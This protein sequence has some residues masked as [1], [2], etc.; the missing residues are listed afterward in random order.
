MVEW[1]I[2]TM[3]EPRELL[4]ANLPLIERAISFACGRFRLGPDDADEFA[5]IVKLRL[6]EKDFA[7]LRAWEGRSSLT[8]YIGTVV[9]RLALDYRTHAWGKWRASAEA[10]RLGALAVDLEQLLYRD[11]R[12]IEDVVAVLAA[13]Y[14]GITRES[15][16]ALAARL[17]ERAP[18]RRD[19][20]LDAAAS[21]ATPQ[22]ASPEEH[23]LDQE[24]RAASQHVSGV[25]A[26]A[27]QKL[28]EQDRLIMQLRFEEGMTVPQIAR[29]LQLDQRQLYHRLERCTLELRRELERE[30]IAARDVADLIGRSETLIRFD[31]VKRNPRP[32]KHH[33]ETEAADSEDPQ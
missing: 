5:S 11:R 9:Q 13:K 2:S 26:A 25:M 12:T 1:V 16:L 23:T 28:L 10:K 17:P 20:D 8:T 22:S 27:I 6:V 32:S 21:V 30:G 24:R 3:K 29:A 7:V 19:V 31:F 14:D 15:L 18:R 33:D 4:T